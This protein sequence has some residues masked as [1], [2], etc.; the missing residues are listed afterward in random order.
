MQYLSCLSFF[1]MNFRDVRSSKWKLKFNLK[2]GVEFR[3]QFAEITLNEIDNT[4][5]GN[6]WKICIRS[7]G[8]ARLEVLD[9]Q[10]CQLNMVPLL[11][12]HYWN[13]CSL[14]VEKSTLKVLSNFFIGWYNCS[15]FRAYKWDT[16][17]P[18]SWRYCQTSKWKVW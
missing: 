16:M 12:K 7:S 9:V 17:H 15:L 10:L 4:F 13:K 11:N 6:L 14:I 18:C 2:L 1:F 8:W 3:T 5:N